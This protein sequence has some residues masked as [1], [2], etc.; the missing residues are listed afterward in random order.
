M[1][2]DRIA[3]IIP[4]AQV[5]ADNASPV[6]FAPNRSI[7]NAYR[8][9]L[10]ASEKKYP[11]EMQTVAHTASGAQGRNSAES[12]HTLLIHTARR[13]AFA[14]ETQLNQTIRQ[15]APEE[16]PYIRH[17]RRNPGITSHIF[18]AAAGTHS[19]DTRAS[20]STKA[21]SS[22]SKVRWPRLTGACCGRGESESTHATIMAPWPRLRSRIRE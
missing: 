11:A 20:S 21:S 3:C 7:G 22:P 1:R 19:R 8:L 9:T 14:A 4:K 10:P 13:R 18:Q 15:P 5:S 12:A 16:A 2:G 6:L 17:K